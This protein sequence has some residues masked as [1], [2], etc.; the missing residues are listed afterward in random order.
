LL[1]AAGIATVLAL[2]GVAYGVLQRQEAQIEARANWEN[3][4][5]QTL[6]G[7]SKGIWAIAVSP[8]QQ[9]LA[10]ASD[11]T[12][13]KLWNLQTGEVLRTLKGHTAPVL[14]VAFSPD[15]Q[16]LASS[17]KD[18]T[19]KLWNVQTGELIRAIQPQQKNVRAVTF[20]PNGTLVSSSWNGV[21]KS[22]NP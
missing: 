11:D 7:H 8:A 17:G 2:S 13:V 14:S 16:T 18:Q 9:V 3:V 19:I 10:T 4:Q 6:Q 5:T 12:T 21:I 22:W 15:G 20:S 1:I